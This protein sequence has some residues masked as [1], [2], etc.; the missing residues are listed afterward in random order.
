MI[1]QAFTIGSEDNGTSIV[2]ARATLSHP[3]ADEVSVAIGSGHY[4]RFPYS[5]ELA[6][7]RN[8]EWVTDI[9]PEFAACADAIAGNTRVYAYV[10]L[11]YFAQ[12]LENYGTGE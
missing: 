4:A 7:F 5:V 3:L 10:P 1:T 11:I 2:N 9:L 6:F 12:F 8:G